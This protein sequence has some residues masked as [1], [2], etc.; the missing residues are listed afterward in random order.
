MSKSIGT[1]VLVALALSLLLLVALAYYTTGVRAE[2]AQSQTSLAAVTDEK[3]ACQ[4]RTGTLE[5]Q[6][7]D[8][9]AALKAQ[10]Q[11]VTDL[12]T[13]LEAATAP[14]KKSGRR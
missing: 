5:K 13:Q 12:Q 11:K 6:L 8:S 1:S 2:L 7:E 4:S 14:A 3:T 10:E 9:A